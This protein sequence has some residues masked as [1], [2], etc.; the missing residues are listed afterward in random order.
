MEVDFEFE[1]EDRGDVPIKVHICAGSFAGVM[2]HVALFPIDT[3]KVK[4]IILTIYLSL[5]YNF[6]IIT[7]IKYFRHIYKQITI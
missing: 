1:R 6:C 7:I 2:E 4:N 5:S 3:I